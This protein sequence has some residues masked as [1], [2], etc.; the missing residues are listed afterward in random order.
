MIDYVA[1]I[2]NSNFNE[3]DKFDDN[4]PCVGVLVDRLKSL[5][6]QNTWKPSDEQV[7]ALEFV[8]KSLDNMLRAIGHIDNVTK[9]RLE[10]ILAALKKLK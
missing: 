6:P 10:E 7:K 9:P 3:N 5:K 8:I 4:K 1:S 2:L